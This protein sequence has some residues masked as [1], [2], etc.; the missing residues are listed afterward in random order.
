MSQKIT[1]DYQL[2]KNCFLAKG[3]TQLAYL[4]IELKAKNSAVDKR[5]SL[6]LCLVMDRSA[7]M[8]GDKIE[9]VKEA[10]GNIIDHLTA[11]DFLA[12][13]IFN[14]EA[15]VLIPAQAVTDKENLK[16]TVNQ[17]QYAGGTSIS[18][19][20]NEGLNEI[21]KHLAD[22]RIN[23]M[24]ILTD[25]QTYGDEEDCFQLATEA[26]EAGIV[27]TAL[28]VG[29]E[30]HED[31]LDTIARGNGGKSDYIAT[32]G[33]INSIF[34]NEINT[35]QH[36]ITKNNVLTLRF[37]S[38]IQPRKV[39]RVLPYIAELDYETFA[40]NEAKINVGE[41]DQTTG[42][43]LLAEIF[44]SPKQEGRCRISQ[45]EL[46]YDVP[47]D[48]IFDQKVRKDI[49]ADFTSDEHACKAINPKVMN[50]AEKVSAYEI[51]TRALTQAAR[52]DIPGATQ[53]LRA[54][55]TR[56]L[57]MGEHDLADATLAEIDNLQKWGSMSSSG[58]KKLRY[59]TRKLT[60]RLAV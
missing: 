6:N 34:E 17:L 22:Q 50:V 60:Q 4:L 7:S 12:I 59:E 55:A 47:G 40:E 16:A 19:G 36:V 10:I 23:R 14:E 56:L 15:E 44:V 43:T 53:K 1:L 35:M 58:T 54:S 25:G 24:I 30:W 3:T 32:A 33:E 38:G 45:A 39:C 20:V 28:G 48:N 29:D 49:I 18:S 13:V 5:P 21:R 2:N 37:V 8:K 26:A 9:K 52:G 27:I 11:E 42:Q 51:Q 41:L 31:V 46:V 57:D